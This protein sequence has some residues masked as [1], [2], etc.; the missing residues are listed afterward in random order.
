MKLAGRYRLLNPL[1]DGAVRLAFD[2][3][4]HRD[5]AVKELRVP[6]Q[7]LQDAVRDAR[8]TAGLRHA[9]LVHVHEVLD[10]GWLVMEFVSG[11]SL[12]TAVT[13]RHPLPVVQAARVG[14]QVFNALACAHAA[15]F[16]HGRVNPGNVMLTTTG[17]AVLT[18]LCGPHPNLPPSADLWS[19][20]A[21]LHFALEGRP[22]GGEP[23][24]AVD[25]LRGLVR[26]M[27]D[28]QVP[29]EGVGRALAE[30]ALDGPGAGVPGAG[31]PGAGAPGAGT[32]GGPLAWPG[33]DAGPHGAGAPGAG[34]SGPPPGLSGAPY[35]PPSGPT[36]P[37]GVPGAAPGA[38]GPE[39]ERPRGLMRVF[40]RKQKRAAE[41]QPAM[42]P[43]APPPAAGA[44][45]AGPPVAGAPMPGV[46]MPGAPGAGAPGAPVAGSPGVAAPSEGP[47]V[48]GAPVAA[49]PEAPFAVPEPSPVSPDLANAVT[50]E[51]PAPALP[52]ASDVRLEQLLE[53]D[54][55]LPPAEVAGLGLDL[56]DQLSAIHANGG[57]H[58]SVCP[59]NVLLADD[60]KASLTPPAPP[61]ASS[62]YTAPE[63]NLVPASDLWSLGATLYT[64]V[65]GRPP[66]PGAPLTR[67]DSLATVLF[68]LLSGDPAQRPAPEAL[69]EELKAIV[70]SR[71]G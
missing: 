43:S 21:T 60:G 57:R 2:E 59:Q 68:K 67:A 17:R 41:P 48:P 24:G 31:V 37:H 5:V 27:L 70:S 33:L 50:V 8:A 61:R 62:P 63:G 69:R 51:H 38:G 65:E 66:A 23:V 49:S 35:A 39:P 29:V 46:P 12:E 3:E 44:P 6:P 52:P 7:T 54:G 14:L 42:P 34:V 4:L 40:R 11:A 45:H 9:S 26:A 53:A 13:S 58:G 64:A 56:L 16:V 55:P 15:G 28:G 47:S 22:P 25:P 19:L 32:P 30:L 1:G 20:A 36:P 18:G 71:A 10:E